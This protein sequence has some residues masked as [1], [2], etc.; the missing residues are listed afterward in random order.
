MMDMGILDGDIVVIQHQFTANNGDVVVAIV[1]GEATLK[2]FKR[3]K[4]HIVLEA[5][6]PQFKPIR[7]KS[8]EIIGKFVGLI[9]PS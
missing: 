2:V 1:E 8:V 9:R 7:P 4:D 5:R 3:E 6:S